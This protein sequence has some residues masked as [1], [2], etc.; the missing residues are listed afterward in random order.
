MRLPT[1]SKIALA[2]SCSF[3]WSAQAPRAPREAFSAAADKGN[4]VHAVA[5]AL[6]RGE[7]VEWATLDP[8]VAALSRGA[9][10]FL[11][12]H[13]HE[14]RRAEVPLAY[15]VETGKARE[16]PGGKHRAYSTARASEVVGTTDI[17]ATATILDWKTGR[18]VRSERAGESPQL[19]TLALAAARAFGWRE[20][21]VGYI[22]L[23]QGDY[24]A[25]LET[26]GA[27]ELD[28]HADLLARIHD[29]IKT[30][31]QVPRPGPH[32]HDGW[33]PIRSV[34]PAT[35]AALAKIDAA[36][37]A[38][39]PASFVV[40]NDDDARR[41]RVCLKLVDDAR[42]SLERSL[43]DYLRQAGPLD[44]GNGK[45]YGVREATRETV[46]LTQDGAQLVIDA[47]AGDALEFG[48]SA[49][50]IGRALAVTM[51]ARGEATRAKKAL[52]E[53]LREVGCVRSTSY[54]RFEEFNKKESA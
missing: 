53:R 50:A 17:L 2:S 15:D 41:A 4:A 16:M 26:L 34:C 30:G 27:W 38:F 22:H 31:G 43:K 14:N 51:T 25:D 29:E 23:E 42:G 32:C 5:E 24:L 36:A 11:R 8:E 46:E 47:G 9:E 39:V 6:V 37:A 28:E 49:E 20:V 35:T 1:A 45:A 40:A 44:L 33:C 52:I 10:A 3:S 48:T 7:A 19:R 54:E 12:D 18:G 13:A 21:Q